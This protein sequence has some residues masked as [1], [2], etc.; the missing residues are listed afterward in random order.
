MKTPSLLLVIAALILSVTAHAESM[1][2]TDFLKLDEGQQHWW[3]FGAIE[4]IGH[5]VYLQDKAKAQC[6]WMWLP[7]EPEKKKALLLKYM[8]D[9]PDRMP[10]SILI[11]LLQRECG[12]FAT[13]AHK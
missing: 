9:N 11:I 10:T 1:K 2:N 6:I 4:G 12:E 5:L 8:K 7:T 3:L 13:E